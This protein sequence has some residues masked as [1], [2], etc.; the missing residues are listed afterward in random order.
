MSEAIDVQPTNSDAFLTA[1]WLVRSQLWNPHEKY[2]LS[3]NI[4][5]ESLGNSH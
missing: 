4:Q 5:T 2:I 3:Q 1:S